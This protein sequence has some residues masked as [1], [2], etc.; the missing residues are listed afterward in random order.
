M[1][2]DLIADTL[3]E[4]SKLK[5]GQWP[6]VVTYYYLIVSL[7]MFDLYSIEY[8]LK[9]LYLWWKAEELIIKVTWRYSLEYEWNAVNK[10]IQPITKECKQKIQYNII[11]LHHPKF[12]T[13][14]ELGSDLYP[15]KYK[16]PKKIKELR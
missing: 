7:M 4:T 12:L 13:R 8:P 14:K 15:T 10:T 11:S 16:S 3:Q 6:F 1:Q 5:N 2:Q 9:R